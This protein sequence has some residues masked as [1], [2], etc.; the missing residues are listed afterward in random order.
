M[1]FHH[2]TCR[3]TKD[4][5][6]Y[7]LRKTKPNFRLNYSRWLTKA[8]LHTRQCPT[9]SVWRVTSVTRSSKS[10][11]W[12][13]RSTRSSSVTA[14][15]TSGES[16]IWYQGE[17]IWINI[18][19]NKQKNKMIGSQLITIRYKLVCFMS[20]SCDE[21]SWP[22]SEDMNDLMENIDYIFLNIIQKYQF[23]DHGAGSLSIHTVRHKFEWRFFS[24][25]CT[26]IED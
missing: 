26:P 19:L 3:D 2:Q 1:R 23:N 16:E 25:S 17:R 6:I 22:R 13:F 24:A 9:F 11:T 15:C 12:S 4:K 8:S 10:R 18:P 5:Q 14:A 7:T 20:S 21:T